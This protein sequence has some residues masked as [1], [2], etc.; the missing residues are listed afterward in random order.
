MEQVAMREG[1]GLLNLSRQIEKTA[2]G[3]MRSQIR[4]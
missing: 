4:E 2:A 3:I 1:V